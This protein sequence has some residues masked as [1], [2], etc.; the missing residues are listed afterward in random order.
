MKKYN[1]KNITFEAKFYN[2]KSQNTHCKFSEDANNALRRFI[3]LNKADSFRHSSKWFCNDFLS[4][5][6]LSI[7]DILGTARDK[8]L[9]FSF[10]LSST[11]GRITFNRIDPTTGK[12]WDVAICDPVSQFLCLCVSGDSTKVSYSPVVWSQIEEQETVGKKRP[13]TGYMRIYNY[14]QKCYVLEPLTNYRGKKNKPNQSQPLT[15]ITQSGNSE[16]KEP[17]AAKNSKKK[18]EK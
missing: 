16:D 17:Q 4:K 8:G 15:Q 10:V 11:G 14:T 12:R 7:Q 6:V 5:T 1:A 9:I 18:Q 2:P 13:P 3:F